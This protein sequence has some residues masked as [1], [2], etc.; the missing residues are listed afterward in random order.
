MEY[1]D[2]LEDEWESF[3]KAMKTEQ[4][5]SRNWDCDQYTI[6]GIGI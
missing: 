5:V 3:Q 2:K 6:I 1:R 4:H